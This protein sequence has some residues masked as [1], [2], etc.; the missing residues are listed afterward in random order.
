M[1]RILTL[2]VLAAMLPLTASAQPHPGGLVFS[3]GS[4]FS[5]PAAGYRGVYIANPTTGA[6]STLFEP[7]AT[8]DPA[9]WMQAAMDRDNRSYVHAV[10][11]ASQTHTEG[12][13]SY[14]PSTGR[15]ATIV[16]APTE[17]STGATGVTVTQDG[18]YL[19][20]SVQGLFRADGSG[21]LTT[22]MLAPSSFLPFSSPIARDVESDRILITSQP[23]IP[24][25][26]AA[27]LAMTY[28]ETFTTLRTFSASLG[29]A[30]NWVQRLA[31]GEFIGT[32]S[33]LR[34]PAELQRFDAGSGPTVLTTMNFVLNSI[35]PGTGVGNCAFENQSTANPQLIVYG[36]TEVRSGEAQ[37]KLEFRDPQNNWAV[38]RTVVLHTGGPLNGQPWHD[39]GGGGLFA[40]SNYIQTVKTG[41]KTWDIKLSAP[42][43]GGKP[44]ALLVGRSGIRPGVGIDTRRI[45]LNPDQLVWASTYNLLAPI[46]DVGPRMLDANGEA[47]GSIDLTNVA[48]TPG[49]QIVTHMVLFVLDPSAPSGVSFITEPKPFTIAS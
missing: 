27:I 23:I 40:R 32:R 43:F 25:G 9:A 3:S 49:T 18:D 24:F 44:Y 42:T 20:T 22:V 48:M 6:W 33:A 35:L 31:T 38:T 39:A 46:F 30:G 26:N 47:T 14:D 41:P 10:N 16:F 34:A 15:V 17:F 7:S 28:D 4:R 1:K 11:N 13:Y 8:Y 45:W 29:A 37:S 21:T 19:I 2:V 12:V 36:A 5:K